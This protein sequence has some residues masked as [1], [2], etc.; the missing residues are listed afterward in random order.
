MDKTIT[1]GEG[2]KQIADRE[3]EDPDDTESG[4]ETDPISIDESFSKVFLMCP[5]N[6]ESLSSNNKKE[7]TEKESDNENNCAVAKNI[8]EN[9][10]RKKTRL[11]LQR[12]SNRTT[13]CDVNYTEE[14]TKRETGSDE[15]KEKKESEISESEREDMNKK[16]DIK[17]ATKNKTMKKKIGKTGKTL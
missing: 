14:D 11:T 1:D 13:K 5:S 12:K 9:G 15:T 10:N 6:P 2:G 7:D 3:K 16:V 17:Y 8:T 4:D